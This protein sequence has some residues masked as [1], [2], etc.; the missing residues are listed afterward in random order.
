MPV[1]RVEIPGQGTFRVESPSEL[2]DAQAY[3]AAMRQS[4]TMQPVVPQEGIGSAFVGGAKRFGSALQTT[5]ESFFDPV[6]AAKRGLERQ[7]QIGQEYAPAANWEKVKQA[8]AERG[9]LPAAGEVLS[10]IPGAFAEQLPNIATTLASAK[11]GAMAGTAV[12]PGIGT[13]VGG[14]GGAALPSLAQLF[15][16]NIERQAEAGATDISRGRALAAA[17]PGAA[18]EVAATFIPLGRTIVGKLLGPAAEK[19]L[20][21]G[22]NEAIERLAKESLLGVVGRGA[23]VGTLAEIP[24]EVAQQILERAQAGLSLTTPDALAEYGQAAYGA[25]LVGAPFGTIGRIGQRS[26]ARGKEEERASE[27]RKLEESIAAAETK[28]A[29]E[30]SLKYKQTPEFRQE[31]NAKIIELEDELRQIEPVAKDKTVDEDV[32]KEAIARANELKKELKNS[33]AEMKASMQGAGVAPTLASELAKRQAASAPQQIVDDFGRVVKPKKGAMT[34]EE[35]AAGYDKE[36]ERMRERNELLRTLREKEEAELETKRQKTYEETQ[37]GVQNYLKQLEEIEQADVDVRTKRELDKRQVGAQEETQ[38]RAFN[39]IEKVVNNFGLNLLGIKADENV[40]ALRQQYSDKARP[41]AIAAAAD[42]E[43]YLQELETLKQQIRDATQNV[44]PNTSES[45]RNF[46]DSGKVNRFVT[47][48]LGVKG[49]EGRTLSAAQALPNIEARIAELEEKRKATTAS[50]KQL[51]EDDGTLTTAGMRLVQDEIRLNELKRL[52]TAAKETPQTGAE[53]ALAGTLQ[54][55]ASRGVE[56]LAVEVDQNLPSVAY[57]GKIKQANNAASGAFDDL[58]SYVD[59]LAKKRFL[60]GAKGQLGFASS[61]EEGLR[62]R[63]NTSKKEIVDKLIEEIAY[64]RAAQKLRPLTRTEATAFA[65]DIDGLVDMLTTRSLAPAPGMVTDTEYVPAQMRGTEIVESAQEITQDKRTQRQLPFGAT[66]TKARLLSTE[67]QKE[68]TRT[69]DRLRAQERETAARVTDLDQR[70]AALEVDPSLPEAQELAQARAQAFEAARTAQTETARYKQELKSAFG[71]AGLS[72]KQAL[73]TVKNVIR[74]LKQ[75]VVLEGRRPVR[76]DRPLLKKQFAAPPADLVKDLDRVL[77]MENLQPDVRD[78]LEQVRR[79]MEEGGISVELEELVEEQVG[80]I[81]RGT[82]RPFVLERDVTKPGGKRAM[83]AAG[84]AE[85]LDEIKTQL[86]LD[87]QARQYAEGAQRTVV[88]RGEGFAEVDVQPSLFP[89]TEATTRATPAMFQRLQKSAPVR[90]E[91]QRIAETKQKA[92]QAAR[93]TRTAIQEVETEYS[94]KNIQQKK[95][96]LLDRIE[97]LA[98]QIKKQEGFD[99]AIVKGF[100]YKWVNSDDPNAVAAYKSEKAKWDAAT[101]AQREKMRVPVHAGSWQVAGKTTSKVRSATMSDR[102]ATQWAALDEDIKK[103]VAALKQLETDARRFKERSDAQAKASKAAKQ[104]KDLVTSIN[105]K[106]KQLAQQENAAQVELIK[107][108]LKLKQN[109]EKR[110]QSLERSQTGFGLPGFKALAKPREEFV[111]EL[112]KARKEKKKGEKVKLPSR[113]K[114]VPIKSKTALD[115]EIADRQREQLSDIRRKAKV[116]SPETVYNKLVE[117]EKAAKEFVQIKTRALNQFVKDVTEGRAA[118][119]LPKFKKMS[120]EVDAAKANLN[121]I[122]ANRRLLEETQYNPEKTKRQPARATTT[123]EIPIYDKKFTPDQLRSMSGM[124][125]SAFDGGRTY[126]V[127][128]TIDFA[129]GEQEGGGIDQAAADARMA[130]VKSKLPADF[131]FKYFP[132]MK[133]VTVDV[134][135]DME[136]Q[137]LDIYTTRVRG[138]VKPDGTVFVIGENHTDMLDLEKTIGHEFVGHYTFEGLLGPDGMRKLLKRAEKS[139]GD[140]YKLADILGVKED[141][142]HAY[143]QAKKL[144]ASDTDADLKALREVIAYTTEKR[145]DKDFFGKAKQWIQ[146][147]VGAFRAALRNMGLLDVSGLSTSDLFYMIKQAD[148]AFAEGKPVAY[149]KANGDIDFAL[150]KPKYAAGLE[151]LGKITDKIIG[152]QD[153]KWNS[154]KANATGL[155]A[156]VQF[157][158]RWAALDALKEKGVEKGVIDSLKAHDMMYFARMADQRHSLTAETATNGALQIKE[159][160][161]PD[162][163]MERVIESERGASL[164]GVSEALVGAGAGDSNATGRLFSLYLAAERAARVGIDKLNFS[165]KITKAD[166]DKALEFGR[167][168]KAFQ[169]AREL[170]NEYN[171]G[172]I[173]FNIQAGSISK[174]LGEKLKATN[175]YVPYYRMRQGT[176]ELIIGSEK[177]IRVGD[178]KSQPYLQELVGG[179]EAIMDFFTSSLQNTSLLTDMALRN[180]AVRNVAFTLKDLGIAEINNGDGPT[181]KDIIRF[182]MD[183]KD[184][185]GKI[186]HKKKWARINVEAKKE[187]FGDIPSELVVTGL[188][189][190]QIVVPGVVRALAAPANWLR[191]FVTRDPRYAVRQIF[192]DSMAGALTTG[193]NMIPV[194]DTL[195]E[196]AKMYGKGGSEAFQKLQSRGVVGGQVITGAPE[197]MAKIAQQIASGKP[198][199]DLAMAKLDQWAISGDAGTRVAMYNSFLKQGLSEREATMAA[200]EAMNFG[201]R[202]VSPSIYFLNATIPFFNAGIQGIDVLYRAFKGK[203]PY[204]QQ[205]QVKK[206][207]LMRGGMMAALTMAYAAMMQDDEAYKDAKPEQRYGNWFVHIPGVEE[208]F[209][210]PIPFEVGL[211]FKALPEGIY[212]A[213]FSDEKGSKVA[214]DLTMQLLR[215]LP[216][217]PAEAGVPVPTAIKPIIETALNRSFFTG[218]DVVDARLEKLDKEYQ[219]RDKT[220]ELLKILGPALAAVNLSPVQMENIIR[221]YTGSMGIGLISIADSVLRPA[222]A[223]GAVEMRVSTM[224]IVGG[225]FQP[226][227]GG[228]VIDEAFDAVKDVQK[229]QSTYKALIA[230]GKTDEAQRYL[231]E[232]IDGIGFASF[233]GSFTQKMGELT[234]A[235]RSIRALPEAS[236][237]PKEKRE[238][239]EELRKIKKDM[240][241]NFTAVRAQIER[242]ASRP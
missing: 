171:R 172:L 187:I 192:R 132:T 213:A 199:W 41:E 52:R 170:Y 86:R 193:T 23:A 31:I 71:T 217:N 231:K 14:V 110:T 100:K 32:R 70:I 185:N 77:R 72:A 121:S 16:S 54:A 55:S 6:G 169:K 60:G 196:L 21:T 64:T 240:A 76:A 190:I 163:R 58:V 65:I 161:R 215:S 93:D 165:G 103:E 5:G 108:L 135:K 177:P 205:L 42:R 57:T 95:R 13:I 239:L 178:L 194:A 61:T 46:I 39:R 144:G 91:Q 112:L 97:L 160:K 221:G 30:A 151:E 62:D 225:L 222:G 81:L 101:P 17:A 223:P 99:E 115:E 227:A 236:M 40:S 156:R 38:N 94:D 107:N 175:D 159:I 117:E 3:Q 138:G 118:K 229:K 44:A 234:K 232:N 228:R 182:S 198:G 143:A 237:S 157:V 104:Q 59:D 168:N 8:Y 74:S 191:K 111:G 158:D 181:G 183:E 207:L 186:V 149:K 25:G 241:A 1:Y 20:A 33:K 206:K 11:A 83:A 242:Q 176:V 82:D 18:L 28:A 212:N 7:E 123:G 230:E 45:L 79:R 48:V 136:R 203:M 56:P 128:D 35:Y 142:L 129:I 233:A 120:A 154:I 127:D 145:L 15:G 80:R 125:L 67:G 155:A 164:K 36:A 134:L 204:E 51:M 12:A 114:I 220:P 85:L 24:T 113:F 209:R 210:V 139:F 188:E 179:D 50:K 29:E 26:V 201:R 140:V 152:R 92:A 130:E 147:L 208:P 75:D 184:D 87:S 69:F 109:V 19:A 153:G 150:T 214:K 226:V 162:G 27:E 96:D 43:A 218:R 63:V 102:V 2:S 105:A 49:L 119:N 89:E 68:I 211:L 22:T 106:R 34:E 235:E 166:L 137:G 73:Q 219:Y 90:K 116:S 148:K 141:A 98:D 146:E 126:S 124:G 197:D 4:S 216:G 9:L 78:T 47:G 202:G 173:D 224:P 131:K 180:L 66:P 84:K 53:A 10:Q 88:P 189:G 174:E 37:T 195:K 167:G 133:D 122:R 200:L 238:R